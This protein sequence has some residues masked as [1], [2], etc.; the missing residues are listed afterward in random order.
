MNYERNK[1]LMYR[2]DGWHCRH[3]NTTQ[4]LTPHHIELRSQGGMDDLDNLITLCLHCHNSVHDGT[5][6]IIVS[7]VCSKFEGSYTVEFKR[8]GWKP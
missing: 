8:R 7:E 4:N 5:L 1:R 6:A 2:R 3:C